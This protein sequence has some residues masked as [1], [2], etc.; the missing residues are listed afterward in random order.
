MIRTNNWIDDDL[1]LDQFMDKIRGTD[2]WYESCNGAYG[3]NGAL[4]EDKQ[5]AQ[6]KALLLRK[7]EKWLADKRMR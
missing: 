5:K 4:L 2:L 7:V 1:D 3:M 6:L